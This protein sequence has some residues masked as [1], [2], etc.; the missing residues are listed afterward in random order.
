[1]TLAYV[2]GR[3]R[4]LVSEAITRYCLPQPDYVIGDVGTTI[5]EVLSEGWRPWVEWL[6]EIAPDWAG[7]GH[8]DIRKLLLDVT[9]LRPQEPEKQ[10]LHKSSYYVPLHADTGVLSQQIRRRLEA[11]GIRV[12][13]VWSIDEPRRTG[14]LDV[15]PASA[16][17]KHAVSFLM[18]HKG[19]SLANTVF[20]GDSGNDL[21][22]LVSEIP[23]VL[24]AN[25][26][27]EVCRAAM[28]QA[29]ECG[30]AD[31]LYIAK[32]G[33][34]DMNGNYTAGVL[35]GVVHYQPEVRS[36]LVEKTQAVHVN[37]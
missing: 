28:D 12:S 16:G 27:A 37:D 8:S 9:E 3:D 15:L 26:S 10:N 23:A 22:V 13:L 4:K 31:A 30:H 24:V 33:F 19:F 18:R 32:G 14:L 2:T 35:E 20:A 6:Q 17:K 11:S 29:A 7:M 25:A 36:W 5:Y 1:V 34:M 21:P